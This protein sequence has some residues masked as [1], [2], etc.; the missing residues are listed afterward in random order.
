MIVKDNR[1]FTLLVLLE[2]KVKLDTDCSVLNE[3]II[4][5]VLN[6]QESFKHGKELIMFQ[7][8]PSDQLCTLKYFKGGE[9]AEDFVHPERKI[10][11]TEM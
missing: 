5:T 3:C 9:N 2:T 11:Q 1:S 8:Q 10:L 6:R 7:Q 4:L